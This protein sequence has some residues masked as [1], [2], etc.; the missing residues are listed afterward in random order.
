VG[1]VAVSNRVIARDTFGRFIAQCELAGEEMMHDMAEDG[2][3]LSRT[4]APKGT[5]KDPRTPHLRDSITASSSGTSAHWEA[6]AR[7]ALAQ[8]KGGAPHPQ[9]GWASFFWEKEG[10]D[11][12]PGPNTISHPGNPAHPYL[13]PAY[14]I[15]MGRWMEYARRYYPR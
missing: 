7:H 10:R 3:A 14:E 11:W 6:N 8:E 12:E 1:S 5:K 15:I 9:T 4:L 13:R 2:A